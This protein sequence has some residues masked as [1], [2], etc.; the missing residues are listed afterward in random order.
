VITDSA[1]RALRRLLLVWLPTAAIACQGSDQG[2]TVAINLSARTVTLT[3]PSGGVPDARSLTV[4]PSIDELNGL[5]TSIAFDAGAAGWLTADFDRSTA[6]LNQPAVLTLTVT[7]NDLPVG[8]YTAAVAIRS[9]NATNS[10]TVSVSFTV[11]DV[12]PAALTV[13]VQ[14]PAAQA[15]GAAFAKAPA[16]QLLTAAAVPAAVSGVPVDVALEGGSGTLQGTAQATTD[17]QGIATFGG[18]SLQG[19]AGTYTLVFNSDGL[20]EA[21]SAPIEVTAGPAA[22][23]A[24]NST[25]SQAQVGTPVGDPPSVLVT[26]GAGNPVAGVAVSFDVTQ[27]DGSIVPTTP[28]T[29]LENGVA[30]LD[31]WTLGPAEGSNTVTATAAGLS[32]SP[33]TFT[34]T[35]QPA[36]IVIGPPNASTSAVCASA[37]PAC[38]ASTTITAGTTGGAATA[39]ITVIARDADNNLIPGASVTLEASGTGNSFGS[40]SLTTGDTGPGLGKATTSFRSTKA[41]TKTITAHISKASPVVTPPSVSV[42]V[43]AAAPN[44]AASTVTAPASVV[45]LATAAPITV[46]LVDEFGNPVFGKS[47]VLALTS[48]TGGSF[49][50]PG[51]TN[52]DGVTIGSLKSTTGGPY[53]VQAS[54]LSPAVTLDQTASVTILL[55]YKLD[56]EPLF[57]SG[58]LDNAIGDGFTERCSDCHK[59]YFPTAAANV[60]DLSLERIEDDHDGEGKVVVR[61]NANAS[62]LIQA[63]KHE[64][65]DLDEKMPSPA[66]QLPPGVIE[67]IARWINQNG[68]EQPLTP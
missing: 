62:R 53:T 22:N 14:P 21:R 39:T 9:S 45:G 32:G 37:P 41:Q 28:V 42:T 55:G 27:G 40:T 30:A 50:Q 49:T 3:A 25:P 43:N 67:L 24:A 66:Q 48:G 47:V 20:T 31:S 2:P 46:T 1:Q 26:D 7:R 15:S 8:G 51:S 19:L 33:V 36:P 56:I 38:A 35:G 18:L 4:T 63:L 65:P 5:S 64:L 52:S 60:P 29:T 23:I 12:T 17:A 10:P 6:T 16:V 61:G 58:T 59:P 68:T 44:K 34:T 57:T 13:V 11:A 54:V